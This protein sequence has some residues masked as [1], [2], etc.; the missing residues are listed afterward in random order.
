MENSSKVCI[1]WKNL[2]CQKNGKVILQNISGCLYYGTLNGLIGPSGSGKS[3]LFNILNQSLTSKLK[4]PK[5]AKVYLDKSN[6]KRCIYIGQ[7]ISQ[8]ANVFQQLKVG[9][10]LRYAYKFKNGGHLGDE[11]KMKEHIKLVISQLMLHADLLKRPYSVCSGGEQ[12]RISIATELMSLVKPSLLLLDEAT[13]GL[14]SA[15]AFEVMQCLKNLTINNRISAMSVFVSIHLPNSAILSLFNQLIVLARGGTCIYSGP[16]SNLKQYSKEIRLTEKQKQ[17]QP[18]ESLLKVA[19]SASDDP[20]FVN[21]VHQATFSCDMFVSD[22]L[23]KDPQ[24]RPI[25]IKR[26]LPD[27]W[28][29]LRDLYY[30][31]SR[32]CRL[33]FIANYSTLLWQM[34]LS[35]TIVILL[36]SIFSWQTNHFAVEPDGCTSLLTNVT[37]LAKLNTNSLLTENINYL[38]FLL[39]TISFQIACTSPALFHPLLQNCIEREVKNC[40]QK[41]VF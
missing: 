10:I 37:C 14:D 3:T 19:F 8:E 39:M 29:T 7:H 11:E 17:V 1:A 23:H 26:H 34:A 30:H 27:K 28:F 4:S 5:S 12:K 33:L 18:I 35:S 22:A 20:L 13:T 41:P 21:L 32:Q 6:F 2:H 24:L 16:S 9:E 25:E 36:S 38:H 31:T 40:K 15:S